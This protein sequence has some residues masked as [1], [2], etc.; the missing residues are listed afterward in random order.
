MRNPK[1]PTRKQKKRIADAKL[2]WKNWLVVS[3]SDKELIIYNKKAKEDE[4]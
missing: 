3:E 2:D 1:K 4:P